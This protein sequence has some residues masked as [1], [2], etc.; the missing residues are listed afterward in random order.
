MTKLKDIYFVGW[1]EKDLDPETIFP[2]SDVLNCEY[3]ERK[4]NHLLHNIF[5]ICKKCLEEFYTKSE[6]ENIDKAI[7][8]NL[9]DP[10]YRE[11][12]SLIFYNND[13]KYIEKC[14]LYIS[15]LNGIPLEI[16]KVLR[17][18]TITFIFSSPGW[19]WENLCGQEGPMSICTKHKKQLSFYA[20]V[21]N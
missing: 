5:S 9:N 21:I 17:K 4:P 7:D 19:T 1:E 18:R 3:I 8:K 14:D 2:W 10:K 15:E 6:I 12:Y 13:L 20:E 16:V 11:K